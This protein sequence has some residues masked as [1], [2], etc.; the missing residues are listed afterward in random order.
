MPN[1]L[2]KEKY[3]LMHYLHLFKNQLRFPNLDYHKFF[4]IIIA[5]FN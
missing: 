1:V 3:N 5:E 2:L 4:I